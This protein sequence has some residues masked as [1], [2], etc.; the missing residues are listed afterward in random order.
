MVVQRRPRRAR[1]TGPQRIWRNTQENALTKLCVWAQWKKGLSERPIKETALRSE[2]HTRYHKC[3]TDRSQRS[4][5]ENRKEDAD[6][7]L[8]RTPAQK[9][10][11]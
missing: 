11:R 9:G 4:R 6:A 7:S 8:H 5:A 1:G 10:K 3:H 2:Q